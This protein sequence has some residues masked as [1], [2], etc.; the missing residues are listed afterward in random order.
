MRDRHRKRTR[1]QISV[2]S[3]NLGAE[4]RAR[5]NTAG[6]LSSS[7]RVV[8]PLVH[9]FV[10]TSVCIRSPLTGRSASAQITHEAEQWQSSV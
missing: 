9:T 2:T 3:T 8:I 6:S 1:P 5:Q 4:I 10:Y 7:H